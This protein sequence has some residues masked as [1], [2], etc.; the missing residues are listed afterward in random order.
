MS[1]YALIGPDG[2]VNRF[3]DN[4]DLTAQTKDG[5]KWLPV[6]TAPQRSSADGQ[7]VEGPVY[8][9][10]TT[11]VNGKP[12]EKLVESYTVRDM[13]PDEIDTRKAAQAAA[14]N[15]IVVKMLFNQENRVRFLEGKPA[16]TI[17]KFK[18]AIKALV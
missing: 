1:R 15:G 17:D 7:V 14:V 16:L 18:E 2:Q 5:W 9:V 3:S 8:T 10:T 11:S 6:E 4:V 13:T 12:T